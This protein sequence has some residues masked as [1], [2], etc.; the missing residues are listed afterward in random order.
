MSISNEEILQ[1]VESLEDYLISTRRYLHENPELSGMEIETSKFLKKEAKKL[2]LA[3][4]EVKGTGFYATLDTGKPGKTV[5]LR[6][7]IDALPILEKDSNQKSMR[8]CKSKVDGIFHACGHDGHMATLLGA[9]KVLV[10]NKD[11]LRGRVIF[12]FEEGEETGSGIF[13]MID[14]LKKENIDAIYGEHLAAFLETGKIGVDAGPVMAGNAIV[15]FTVR[16]KGGHGSRPDLSISPI[17]A[18]TNIINGLASAWINRIDVS[19]TVTLGLGLIN[20]GAIANVIPDDV[21][22]AGTLRYFDTEEG[23]KALELVKKVGNL[24]AQAHECEFIINE[25]YHMNDPVINNEQL[26]NLAQKSID[27]IMPGS[28]YKNL[29]WFASET[30]T[31]YRAVSDIVFALVGTKNEELGSGAEHHNEYFD[32]DEKSIIIGTTAMVKFVNDFLNQN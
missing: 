25:M 23:K 8:L 5:G 29:T 30:F 4:T 14:A 2:N 31:E 32:I 15:D 13:N 3:I 19:K 9:M 22:V 17:F 27:D 11:K 6:T 18:A 16:G 24:T 26:A 21:R 12:I 1:S 7:D 20:G 10:E 28:I